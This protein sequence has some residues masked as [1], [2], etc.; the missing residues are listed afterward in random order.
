MVLI[1]STVALSHLLVPNDEVDISSLFYPQEALAMGV[2]WLD[3]FSCSVEDGLS[4]GLGTTKDG[5][6][7]YA[8]VGEAQMTNPARP[9]AVAAYLHDEESMYGLD[10]DKDERGPKAAQH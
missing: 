10:T 4:D 7:A 5:D 3:A 1:V 8:V 9:S 6:G 2:Y